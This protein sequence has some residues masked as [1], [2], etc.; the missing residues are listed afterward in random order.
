ML[1]MKTL[2]G[3]IASPGLAIGKVHPVLD[4]PNLDIPSYAI[5]EAEIEGE[6]ARFEKSCE[7]A[8]ATLQSLHLELSKKSKDE[9]DILNTY[10]AMLSDG[11]FIKDVCASLKAKMLNI[12]TVL[13]AKIDEYASMLAG[14]PSSYIRERALDIKDAFQGVFEHLLSNRERRSRFDDVPPNSI[15][16]A[17]DIMTSE[18]FALKTSKV[19]GIIMEEGGVM[20]HISIIA[21]SWGIPM[22]VSVSHAMEYAIAGLEACL[23]AE[24][25]LVILNPDK[26]EVDYYQAKI[27]ESVAEIEMMQRLV[28]EGTTLKTLDGSIVSVSANIAFKDEGLSSSMAVADGVGLFRTEFLFLQDDVIPSEEVQ[29]EVYSAVAKKMKN[30][31]LIIR[32][33][34]AGSDKMLKEQENLHEKNPLLGWRAIRY[35]FAR[36]EIFRRQLRAILKSSAHGNVHILIPMISS[37]AEVRKVRSILEEEKLNLEVEGIP[38]NPNIP[39]GIMVE[40]PSVA[41]VADLFAPYVDFMSI[42][43][44][45]LVQYSMAA[46]RENGKVAHLVN[47]FEP[48]VLR[49][50]KN[51]IASI[52]YSR[53]RDYFVS[54]CGEMASNKEA[55]FL[56][57]GM[58]LRHFSMPSWKI[59]EIKNFISQVDVSEAR[60]VYE[61][62]SHLSS[63][64]DILKCV[65]DE[66]NLVL[67]KNK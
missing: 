59:C 50:I 46:D 22:L 67:S 54:M 53:N 15:I 58:G 37:I 38:F 23:D 39:L 13:E 48:A 17:R 49:L 24:N 29:E 8:I 45:D 52:E 21:R 6:I 19:K 18:V 10:I 4:K 28:S 25:G 2:R 33:F 62:V 66:L 31:P 64:E 16:A 63:V 61:K 20:G 42:G 9:A 30:K 35:C 43:T 12:E 57:L 11:E 7:H 56:L 44:N 60:L 47:Y 5:G 55:V 36:P 32:T 27:D 34:D 65:R 3:L 1:G 14:S 41:I 40:V 51:T 26:E